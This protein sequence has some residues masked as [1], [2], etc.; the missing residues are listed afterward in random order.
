M[1]SS[2]SPCPACLR[3]STLGLAC[4]WRRVVF[5]V[6]D[7]AIPTCVS[8]SANLFWVA[9]CAST[10]LYSLSGPA[11]RFS[12]LSLGIC[13][14]AV[15]LSEFFQVS[16]PKIRTS[17]TLV[18]KMRSF[19][20]VEYAVECQ[21]L[22][23]ALNALWAFHMRPVV[24]ASVPPVLPIMLPRY[25]NCVTLPVVSLCMQ[26]VSL[27]FMAMPISL[28]LFTLIFKPTLAASLSILSSVVYIAR[29]EWANR[30]MS[31]A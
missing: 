5:A 7:P 20:C 24:S 8:W 25:A 6:Y 23:S 30:H 26:R 14:W 3:D 12:I 21:I 10:A 13:S 1:Y 19:V 4:L 9:S 15:I 31:S 22:L 28:D 2:V 11:R 27:M 29:V 17:F 18:L 16:Q